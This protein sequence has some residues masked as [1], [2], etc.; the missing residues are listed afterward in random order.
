LF[1]AVLK[2]DVSVWVKSSTGEYYLGKIMFVNDEMVKVEFTDGRQERCL[3]AENYKLV[4]DIVP[5]PSN[6]R[7]GVRVIAQFGQRHR[8][9]PGV[10][11]SVRRNDSYDILFDDGDFGRGKCFQMRILKNFPLA[12]RSFIHLLPVQLLFNSLF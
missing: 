11:S 2:K 6:L 5:C 10:I 1:L 8:F 7:T 9:Y 12:S 4:P 3:R